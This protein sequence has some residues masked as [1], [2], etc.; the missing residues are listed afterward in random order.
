M[1]TTA[2]LSALLLAIMC[3]CGQKAAHEA[4]PETEE[5][6]FF[7]F[8]MEAA[9]PH[10]PAVDTFNE[11]VDSVEFIL[12]ETHPEAL[13]PDRYVF[14]KIDGDMFISGGGPIR[15]TPI[16]RFD[17]GGKFVNQLFHIGRGPNEVSMPLGWHANE[18]LHQIDFYGMNGRMVVTSTLSGEKYSVPTTMEQGI[19]RIPLGDSTFVSVPWLL[20]DVGGAQLHFFDRTG[21][22]IHTKTRNDELRGYSDRSSESVQVP[23]YESYRLWSDYHGDAIFHDIFNDT[24]YRI[25]NRHEITPHIVLHRS[26]LAPRPE[27]TFNATNKRQ[28]AYI[29]RTMESGSF[30][31]VSYEFDGKTWRDVWSKRDGSLMIHA[32]PKE[33]SFP[34]DIFMPWRLPDGEII[35]LQVV[36]ADREHAYGVMNALHASRFMPGV[37]ED[38]NPVIVVAKLK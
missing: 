23:P 13:L 14:T 20:S 18:Q 10:G 36:Y 16:Y 17:A 1:K 12:L 2:I 37:K 33:Q 7:L 5:T 30:V 28:Q 9:L 26:T 27:D 8:D 31:M 35:A 6:D 38:D 4:V 29:F 11:L 19:E 24:L 22:L 34:F 21:N 25:K 32:A 15:M 3:G